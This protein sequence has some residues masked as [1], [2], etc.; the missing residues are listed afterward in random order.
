MT[1][2]R[3]PPDE[4]QRRAAIHARGVNVIADAGAGTGKTTLL[5]ARL[6][7]MVAPSDDGPAVP[8]PR[9]AA[10]TFT[11]KAAGELK[12]RVREAILRA[13]ADG[14][15]SPLRRGR[16]SAA[17][18]A[19]DTAHVGTIHSFADRLLRLRPVEARLSPSY[20]I[21]EDESDLLRETFEVFLQAVEAGT[22][23]AEL[24][25]RVDGK[26]AE[27]AS[28]AVVDALRAG[29]RAAS[30]PHGHGEYP[31]LDRL[32]ERL[33]R[34][35]DVRPAVPPP[36]APDLP[37]F[38]ELVAELA[39]LAEGSRG[40]GAGSRFLAR[41][42]ARLRRLADEPDPVRILAELLRIRGATPKRMRKGVDFEGDDPGWRAW[43]AFD[44]DGGK[45]PVRDGPLRDDLLLPFARWLGRRLVAAAPAVVATYERVKARHRAIDQVDLLLEL[46]DLLRERP[47]VRADYQELL[48]HVFVDELQDTDPL[49]AEIVLFLCEDGARAATWRDVALVPGKLTIVGDPKQSIYRFRR[50]DVAAYAQVRAIVQRGPHLVAKLSASFRGHPSLI[51]WLNDRFD[52]VLGTAEPGKPVFDAGQG[53]VAN[54]RLVAALEGADGPRVVVLPLAA[55]PPRKP[56]YRAAEAKALASWLRRTVEGRERAVVDPVTGASRP[57]GWGDV[58]VLAASTSSLSVLFPELDRLGVPY[59]ARGGTLFLSDPLHCQFL[60]ALRAVADRDDGVAQ[61]ALLRAPFFAIDHD[62]LARERA[63]EPGSTHAGVLRARAAM[64]LL[65]E[66]RTRR[67]ERPPGATARDLL[68]R[69]AF[70]RAVALGPNGAQRLD[71]LRELCF[72]LDAAAAEGLDFDGATARLRRWAIEPVALDPPRPVAREAVQILTVHQAKGLEFPIVALWDACADLDARDDRAVFS[73]DRDGGA[74]TLSLDGL[75]CEE[76]EGGDAAARERRYLDAERKRLVYVAATRAR[77]LLVLPVAGEPNPEWISGRLV[78]GGPAALTETLDAFAVGAEPAWAAEIPS[79]APRPRG[80]ASALAAEVSS[81]WRRAAE[82]AARPRFAPA[83]VSA[84]AHRLEEER[85][86]PGETASLRP[87]RESRF[88]NVFGETVHRAIGLALADATLRPGSAIDRAARATGL[89]ANRGEAADDVRRA[90]AALERA[91]LR[92]VPGPDLRLEYPVA[93]AADGR[94]V[95]GYVDLVGLREDRLAVVDFKTD[96]PPQGDVARTHAP[97]VEQVRSYARILEALGLAPGGVEAGLLFTA[98]EEVRWVVRR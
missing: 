36:Q 18:G 71:A 10:I 95:V 29:I 55:D 40:E 68:E 12:L 16:L 84:E 7:E 57:A 87:R 83:A 2:R 78:Q 32:F 6:V 54:E 86:G 72:A 39:G 48:D 9:L 98:E 92:R 3:P 53:T 61:A 13:L 76:P 1:P 45:R 73:V 64:A 63:A 69:T 41:M 20:E 8:L 56:E 81:A 42:V 34:T 24:E 94:L 27:E 50:A 33:V 62:D 77:D 4:A 46:R 26:V 21:V 96:A 97:Y 37:R 43:K 67:L 23:A 30:V 85:L 75:A 89:A 47:D 66:L 28:R 22:L 15:L 70:G 14:E 88:G 35:R 17:L 44:G 11:R 91:G 74:W 5:V 58:A 90:L 59:A 65:R 79:P 38:R 82:D 93:L 52:E 51:A 25:G 80:D 49:Q 60:L 19:L 31:G